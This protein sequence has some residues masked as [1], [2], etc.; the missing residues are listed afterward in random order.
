MYSPSHIRFATR[1]IVEHQGGRFLED[2]AVGIDPEARLVRLQSGESLQYDLLSCNVGSTVPDRVVRDG[3]SDV[4]PV[5]PIVKLLEARDRIRELTSRG[6]CRLAVVG[7]GPAALEIAANARALIRRLGAHPAEI[8][9]FAGRG[10]LARF[11]SRLRNRAR[12]V[13]RELEVDL[14]ERGYVRQ[15]DTGRLQLEDG[16]QWEADLTLLAL[17]VR[18]PPL[19]A[20]TGP[21][22]GLLVEEHLRSVDYPEILGGGDCIAYRPRPLDKVGVYAVRQNP[23]LLHNLLAQLRG[24]ELET[25]R[26]QDKYMLIFNTGDGKGILWRGDLV[27]RGRWAFRLKD[28]IDRKFMRRFQALE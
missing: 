14:T 25:F 1:R 26:P 9:L 3:A 8:T 21:E 28:R 11:P 2:R 27:L 18:P 12:G 7:G 20:D 10:L 16:S 23:I 6:P 22:G 15:V 19:F 13:L 17:G 4:F 5:K 24:G